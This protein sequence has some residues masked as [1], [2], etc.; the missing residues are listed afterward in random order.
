MWYKKDNI[1]GGCISIL[2]TWRICKLHMIA[3][4]F[5][6]SKFVI[7]IWFNYNLLLRLKYHP[8]PS[9]SW[10]PSQSILSAECNMCT[11][12][13]G[14]EILERHLSSWISNVCLEQNRVRCA[15]FCYCIY[16]PDFHAVT[17]RSWFIG[18]WQFC[19]SEFF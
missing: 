13:K 16:S 1:Q 5:I 10:K 2:Y 8:L 7:V 18:L 14:F 11:V 17:A 15:T 19:A 4:R 6:S 9:H 12:K 3:N